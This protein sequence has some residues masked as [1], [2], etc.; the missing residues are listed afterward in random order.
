MDML[1]LV[2]V[3]IMVQL[4]FHQLVEQAH[5]LTLGLQATDQDLQL[6]KKINLDLLRELIS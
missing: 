2:M 1:F 6:D 3:E 5:T 4:I